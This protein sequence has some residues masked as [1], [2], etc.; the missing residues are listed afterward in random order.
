MQPG[1][2]DLDAQCIA[3]VD[4]DRLVVQRGCRTLHFRAAPDAAA[5]LTKWR[6]AI[7]FAAVARKPSV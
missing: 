4:C 6:D 1:C 2:F 3:R 5:S 7:A